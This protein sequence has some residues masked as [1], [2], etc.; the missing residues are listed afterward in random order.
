MD[1]YTHDEELEERTSGYETEAASKSSDQVA[2]NDGLMTIVDPMI[3][4][5]SRDSD[6]PQQDS[7]LSESDAFFDDD[8]ELD[9]H[10]D[11]F[12]DSDEEDDD[13]EA[14]NDMDSEAD[15]DV[16]VD[17]TDDVEDEVD[18]FADDI[19]DDDFDDD[20]QFDQL[21]EFLAD[22]AEA[23]DDTLEKELKVPLTASQQALEARRAIE[24]RA[25][26]RRMER[27][28]NY[29]DFELDD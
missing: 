13:V 16:A 8:V 22:D 10:I 1:G 26:A 21:D 28:L 14:L 11:D 24:E 25:E 2:D 19:E 15:S 5:A 18:E 17:L 6:H 3:D 9:D 4:K 23:A 27:D 12:D 7:S 20:M 29:L